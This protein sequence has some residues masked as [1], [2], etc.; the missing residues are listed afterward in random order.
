M[1]YC[2]ICQTRYDEEIMH[3]CTKDGTPL[4][5]EEEPN[6]VEMP[7]ESLET[8]AAENDLDEETVI[9]RKNPISEPVVEQPREEDHQRLVVPVTDERDE[10][11]VRTRTADYQRQPPPPKNPTRRWSC[12]EQCSEQL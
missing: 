4:I 7:S 6:F 12:W 11:Q 2:P 10:Q 5:D 1:K 9:R 8:A 3:F